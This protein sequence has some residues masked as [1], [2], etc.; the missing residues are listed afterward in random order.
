MEDCY[1]DS[2]MS[3]CIHVG[4]VYR[5]CRGWRIQ[6]SYWSTMMYGRVKLSTTI[7]RRR[8]AW[9]AFPGLSLN[10]R[11][12]LVEYAVLVNHLLVEDS[13]PQLLG[14]STNTT[15]TRSLWC[16]LWTCIGG[17]RIVPT[18]PIRFVIGLGALTIPTLQ[19]CH[20]HR[21]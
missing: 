9:V 18:G 10:L 7:G 19:V 4:I 14:W 21:P 17:R 5:S 2:Y 12:V 6:T 20:L 3:S 13:A 15:E 16:I 1:S 11:N 8:G